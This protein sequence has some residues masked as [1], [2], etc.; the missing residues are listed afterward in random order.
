MAK[1]TKQQ[2]QDVMK[3]T[4]MIP[5]FYHADVEVAKGV[6]DAAYKGGVRIFE[7]T[8]RG[9]NAFDVFVQLLKHAEQ[10]PDLIMG[11]GT[12]MDSTVAQKFIEAGAHFIVSPILNTEMAETCRKAGLMWVPGCA[13]LTEIVTGKNHG[14]EVIK[15]F[16]GSVL[17]PGFVSAVMPVVP[18]LQLM[19]T[20]GVEPTE[21]NLGAWFKAGVICVG[22][23]SQLF[24]KEVISGKRWNELEEKVKSTMKII[25]DL[26][27]ATK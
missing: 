9:G 18:G 25:K 13:T 26:K 20:G 3:S 16:P 24:T 1:Y 6:I 4:G 23:G 2:V 5:V 10:Y 17:G 27:S 7:F 19:P 22:M 11:I 15:I 21:Q 8:N 14:A 12:I